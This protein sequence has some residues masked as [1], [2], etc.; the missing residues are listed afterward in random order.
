M[1]HDTALLVG[2]GGMGEVYKAWDPDLERWVAFKFLKHGD[3]VLVERLQREARVQARVD[4]PGVCQVYE[5]GTQDGRPFIAM[6]YVDGRPLDEATRNLSLEEKVLVVKRVAEAVQAAHAVG[7]IHRDLKPANILVVR[8]EDGELRPYVLDFGVAREHEVQG[9]TLTGQVLGTPGYLSPEQA[10]GDVG[11]LDRR[12]D[13]FSLGV[14]LYELIAGARPFRGDSQVAMLMSLLQDEPLPLRQRVPAVPRDLETVVMTCLE[15][16][17]RRRYPSARALADDLGRF[18]DGEPVEARPVSA[19]ERMLRKAR[20]HPLVAGAAVL[21]LLVVLSLL[22]ALAWSWVRYTRDLERERAVAVEA[23]S[24]AERNATQAREVTDFMV[25]L[26][27][28]SSPAISAG[29]EVT[30]RQL[31]EEGT[32]RI[33]SELAEQPLTRARLLDSMAEAYRG[34][35][36]Y[37]R[38]VELAQDSLELRREAAG[39]GSLEAAQSLYLL[40]KLYNN[41]RKYEWAEDAFVRALEI[42]RELLPPGDRDVV[43]AQSGLANALLH[44]GRLDEAETHNRE[45]VEAFDH[46][47]ESDSKESLFPLYVRGLILR[48]QGDLEGSEAAHRAYVEGVRRLHGEVHPNVSA[49]LNNLALVQRDRGDLEGAEQSLRQSLAIQEELYE[50]GHPGTLATLQNLADLL[51][52]RGQHGDAEATLRE[53][54]RL[55]RQTLPEGHWR[56]GGDVMALGRML[57]F[58]GRYREAEPVLREGTGIWAAGIGEDHVWTAS[59]RATVG[60]CLIGL[61][62]D[63]EGEQLLGEAFEDL[64]EQRSPTPAFRFGVDRIARYLDQVGR[65]ADAERFRALADQDG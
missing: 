10:R 6:Q 48:R 38:A 33:E 9:L 54:L 23:Q 63:A 28:V 12:S 51:A 49:A 3:P 65:P 29:E 34:L 60:V 21:S 25:G 8:A 50:A 40:G 45:V 58:A 17:P 39:E 18:L 32:R 7:L 62:R 22:A 19:V 30:A 35:G 15:K 44:V 27:E 13:V 11:T 16:D 4:H 20:K 52:R 36:R 37:D 43:L 2:S 59:A 1:R 31:L 53:I 24:E 14:I 57:M 46:M 41:Q 5:V 61:G 56:I 55:R 26:F 42:R 64:R 47:E